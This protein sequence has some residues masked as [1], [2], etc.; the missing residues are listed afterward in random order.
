M[1]RLLNRLNIPGLTHHSGPEF[2]SG[3]AVLYF[4]RRAVEISARKLASDTRLPPRFLISIGGIELWVCVRYSSIDRGGGCARPFK[5][6]QFGDK[7][8]EFCKKV[9][10][11]FTA[12]HMS[13]CRQKN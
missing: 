12:T 4:A 8:L 6:L 10:P 11:T 5:G 9:V 1:A 3:V 7:I 13:D 2:A